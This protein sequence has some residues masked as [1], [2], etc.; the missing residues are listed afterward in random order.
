MGARVTDTNVSQIVGKSSKK[1]RVCQILIDVLVI[2]GTVAIFGIV[3]KLVDPK[4]RYF[5]CNENDIFHPYIKDTIPY[6]V[7]AIFGFAGPITIII[8][9]EIVS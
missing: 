6:W 7:V 2:S 8:L 4:I 5:Y 9:V 3:Y 1:R